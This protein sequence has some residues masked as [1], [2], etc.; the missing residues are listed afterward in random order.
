MTTAT[1]FAKS[2]FYSH[3]TKNAVHSAIVNMLFTSQEK[4]GLFSTAS[5]DRKQTPGAATVLEAIVSPNDGEI[6]TVIG[7]QAGNG[8]LCWE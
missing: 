7:L 1:Y 6:L 8:S 3:N 5:R 2:S 4:K